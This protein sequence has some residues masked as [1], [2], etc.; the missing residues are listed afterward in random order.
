[1]I[2]VYSKYSL[3]YKYSHRLGEIGRST[4]PREKV[5]HNVVY[6]NC[7]SGFS[8][9]FKAIDWLEENCKDEALHERI[10]TNDLCYDVSGLFCG[11][12]HHP[13]LVAVVEALCKEANGPCVN[14]AIEEISGNKYRIGDWVF[15]ND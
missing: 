15:I 2:F 1:M 11:K 3:V 5:M 12:R 6:N 4:I 10:K 14:L 8:L 9:S 13:D 7:Y